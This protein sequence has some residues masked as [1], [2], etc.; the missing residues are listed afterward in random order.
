MT[1]IK[2]CENLLREWKAKAYKSIKHRLITQAKMET[3]VM[4]GISLALTIFKRPS[5][6]KLKMDA[7]TCTNLDCNPRGYDRCLDIETCENRTT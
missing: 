4:M 1:K 7:I 3:D 5:N 6:K 2:E